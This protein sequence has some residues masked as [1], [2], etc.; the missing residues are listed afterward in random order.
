MIVQ[1]TKNKSVSNKFLKDNTNVI[2]LDESVS[3]KDLTVSLNDQQKNFIKN[4]IKNRKK[5]SKFL[6]F[7][8]NTNIQLSIII[9]VKNVTTLEIQKLGAEFLLFLENNNCSKITIFNTN[10]HIK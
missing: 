4:K 5:G 6:L 1:V 8:L 7:D 2:F 9:I 10:K 3:F